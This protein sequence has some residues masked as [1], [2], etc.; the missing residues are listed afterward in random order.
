MATQAMQKHQ[1]FGLVDL[2]PGSIVSSVMNL[3]STAHE[4]YHIS[5]IKILPK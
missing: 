3:E 5:L 4:P 1:K 2:F